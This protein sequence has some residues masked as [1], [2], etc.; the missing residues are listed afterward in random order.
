M[1]IASQLYLKVIQSHHPNLRRLRFRL[2]VLLVQYH[3][4]ED[5]NERPL[6]DFYSLTNTSHDTIMDCFRRTIALIQD[7]T[8]TFEDRLHI[9]SFVLIVTRSS[10]NYGRIFLA[11]RALYWLCTSMAYLPDLLAADPYKYGKQ[12][13]SVGLKYLANQFHLS[14]PEYISEALD[15]DILNTVLQLDRLFPWLSDVFVCILDALHS[16][17]IFRGVERRAR[18]ALNKIEKHSLDADLKPGATRDA[19]LTMKSCAQHV[20]AY[21]N[22]YHS[23]NYDN[24]LQCN[25]SQCPND[26]VGK[27][28]KRCPSCWIT[29]YCSRSCQKVDWKG[30][31]EECHKWAQQRKDGTPGPVGKHDYF[32]IRRY[33]IEELKAN[34]RHIRDLKR[35]YL[36]THPDIPIRRLVIDCDYYDL[37]WTFRII[38]PKDTEERVAG[39]MPPELFDRSDRGKSQL[40]RLAVPWKG[41]PE[42]MVVHVFYTPHYPSDE[43]LLIRGL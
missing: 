33:V 30:H 39:V 35:E 36:K 1:L 42:N 26:S 31:R 6:T 2:E 8:I 23:A 20:H 27:H 9:H 38:S 22:Y 13:L 5:V 3:E 16:R 40:V 7:S 37:S 25:N 10:P 32:F 43:H 21:K 17:L 18:K 28:P 41:G 15:A 19:W 4:E 29:L 14:G 34:G 24:E 12:A 11:N